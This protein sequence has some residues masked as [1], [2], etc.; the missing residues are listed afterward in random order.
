M[1]KIFLMFG[2]GILVLFS[3]DDPAKKE[4]ELQTKER[5]EIYKQVME[6]HDEMM[7]LVFSKIRPTQKKLETMMKDAQ[8]QQDSVNYQ[9]YK[10]AFNQLENADKAMNSWM[11]Q[12]RN[13][14]VDTSHE[15]AIKYLKDQVVKVDEMKKVMEKNI[16][17]AKAVIDF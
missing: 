4:K 8:T 6:I 14:D 16:N 12:F 9:K 7:P 15:E 13:P 3:C 5:D 11:K 17:A 10:T 1:N 2:V